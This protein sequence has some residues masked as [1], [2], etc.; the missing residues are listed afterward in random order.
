MIHRAARLGPEAQKLSN[1]NIADI[2]FS[3]CFLFRSFKN[4]V[5]LS[6]VHINFYSRNYHP[7]S[8]HFYWAYVVH[9]SNSGPRGYVHIIWRKFPKTHFLPLLHMHLR[10]ILYSTVWESCLSILSLYFLLHSHKYIEI[11]KMK[12]TLVSIGYILFLNYAVWGYLRSR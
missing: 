6:G 2:K 11:K 12:H 4:E 5:Q 3:L 7:I 8:H 1:N 9:I 10:E